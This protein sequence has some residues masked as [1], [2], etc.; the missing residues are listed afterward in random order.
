MRAIA[1]RFANSNNAIVIF[2]VEGTA[3]A[4]LNLAP[5][6]ED[7]WRS[8][9]ITPCINLGIRSLQAAAAL[10]KGKEPPIAIRWETTP[11]AV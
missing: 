9:G 3:V 4:V 10:P 2:L 11:E 5:R 1:N 6:P 7:V 8:A